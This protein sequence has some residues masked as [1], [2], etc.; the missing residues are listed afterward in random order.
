M[1]SSFRKQFLFQM[2]LNRAK[3]LHA[4][5]GMNANQLEQPLWDDYSTRR[6]L[7]HIALWEGFEAQ[8][9]RLLIDG[10]L[11]EISW[12]PVDERNAAWHAQ[13]AEISIDGS[14]A[15][16]QKERNGLLNVLADAPDKLLQSTVKLGGDFELPVMK[17]VSNSIEH[18]E[19]HAR[20]IEAWRQANDA[21][22]TSVGPRS[23]L[24][25][26]LRAT[27]NTLRSLFELIAGKALQIDNWTPTEVLAHIVGWE[28]LLLQT[29]ESNVLPGGEV[30][31]TNQQFVD[32]H[33]DNSVD[34]LMGLFTTCR[35][36]VI[37]A[38]EKMSDAQLAGGFENRPNY[39]VYRMIALGPAHDLE[40][41]QELYTAW[42][43]E[44][45]V[46]K[47]K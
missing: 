40:H 14:I 26:Q 25:A 20:D 32:E 27:R 28:K 11:D 7:P 46:K 12:T 31:S 38:V 43:I 13:S 8:R 30:D 10:R 44:T 39:P 3:L 2:H 33:G 36:A 42:L 17:V 4:M 47:A 45:R 19:D 15:M 18:D 34:E 37:N 5:V 16:L 29:L 9:L 21:E 6:V 35:K 24:V 1:A 22:K 41:I 23:I